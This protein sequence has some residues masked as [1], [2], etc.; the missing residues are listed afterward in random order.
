MA[1][2]PIYIVLN[3]GSGDSDT[4]T[5]CRE[6]ADVLNADGRVHQILR[7][8]DPERLGEI[9]R[10]AVAKAQQNAGVVVAAGGDGT[11]NSVAQATLGSGCQFGVIPQGTFNYFGRT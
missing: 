7:V 11:L 3:A 4:E 9:A 2:A 5:T 8:D 10:Q 6:I 1:A